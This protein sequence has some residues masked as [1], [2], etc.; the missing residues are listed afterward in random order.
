MKAHQNIEQ[1][2]HTKLGS[3]ARNNEM[4]L[5]TKFR[6]SNKS[7]ITFPKKAQLYG[8]LLFFLLLCESCKSLLSREKEEKI[9]GLSLS[10]DYKEIER[11]IDCTTE[12][13]LAINGFY[14]SGTIKLNLKEIG[15]K[16]I[17]KVFVIVNMNLQ[18]EPQEF[19]MEFDDEYYEGNYEELFEWLT[20]YIRQK[21]RFTEQPPFISFIGSGIKMR[22]DWL[23]GDKV[24]H[25]VLYEYHSSSWVF[26]LYGYSQLENV[27]TP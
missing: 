6:T 23:Y 2:E 18:K 14:C 22:R 4:A 7:V 8:T 20:K 13:N 12:L 9:F 11:Y 26:L 16:G 10:M 15:G 21:P 24:L 5:Y 1:Y 17:A 27:K 25:L 19:V 3:K